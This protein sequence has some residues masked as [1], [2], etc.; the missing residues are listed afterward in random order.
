MDEL[1]VLEEEIVDKPGHGRDIVVVS[2]A[3]YIAKDGID[4]QGFTG[5]CALGFP[6]LVCGPL[7]CLERMG[8][9]SL[10]VSTDVLL[11]P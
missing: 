10:E 4:L 11:R 1:A 2:W 5:V 7:E 8:C 9:L 3:P 6:W